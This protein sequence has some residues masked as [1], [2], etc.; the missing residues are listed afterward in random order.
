MSSKYIYFVYL[1]R[2]LINNKIYV[3]VHKTTNIDDGYMGS[4]KY[5]QRAIK[6]Y[7]VENFSR[8]IL[9]VT[10]TYNQSFEIEELIVDQ[11]FVKSPK[12]YNIKLGGLGGFDHISI[13]KEERKTRTSNGGTK[14]KI[15]GLG[16][17]NP[18]YSDKKSAWGY[19]GAKSCKE[20]QK[21][22]FDL[23]VQRKIHE[24]SMSPEANLKRIKTLHNIKHQQGTLNS[25]Y[26]TMWIFNPDTMENRKI[27]KDSE[28]PLGYIKG[29]HIK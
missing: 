8:E 20:Q 6:K 21:G 4:G 17:H 24:L 22:F 25:Q 16:V 3:G 14:S 28:I 5:L 18:I 13:S 15:N 12:T 11:K 9:C 7:G 1:T 27:K 10:E 29:R 19:K 2:N 26:G 23:E